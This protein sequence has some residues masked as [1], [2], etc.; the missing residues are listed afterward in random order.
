LRAAWK[1]AWKPARQ[2]LV[3][4]SLRVEEDALSV[5]A[6]TG[7]GRSERAASE[8]KV[9]TRRMEGLKAMAGRG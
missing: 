6:C 1:A 3:T 7:A 4:L 2:N 5:S 9:K 8:V